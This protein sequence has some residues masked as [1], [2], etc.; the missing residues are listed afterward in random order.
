VRGEP[1]HPNRSF[2]LTLGAI[3]VGALALGTGFALYSNHLE[4]ESDALCSTTICKSTQAVDLNSNA[5]TTGWIANISWGA[6]A[7]VLVGA[8]AA[9]WFG[10]TTSDGVAVVPTASSRQAGL[11]L[12]GRF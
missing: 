3:G 12:E 5:R 7:A 10:G 4:T 9:W 2:P 8:A 6:G 11:A 1:A